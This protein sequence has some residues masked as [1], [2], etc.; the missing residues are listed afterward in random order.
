MP[1]HQVMRTKRKT[2]LQNSLF[3][4]GP[5]RRPQLRRSSLLPTIPAIAW[6][7]KLHL[8]QLDFAQKQLGSCRSCNVLMLV[9]FAQA[10]RPDVSVVFYERDSEIRNKIESA[11]TNCLR[12]GCPWWR[13]RVPGRQRVHMNDKGNIQL[14][15]N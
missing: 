3:I 6:A 10:R 13:A 8:K 15:S 1:P 9:S 2:R 7:L 12:N 5:L 11:R 4:C 14:L